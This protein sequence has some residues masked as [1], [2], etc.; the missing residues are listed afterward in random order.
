VMK[1]DMPNPHAIYLHDTPSKQY[2]NSSVRAFSHGCVRTERA[3]E[4]GMT[5]AIF[6]AGLDTDAV[7]ANATSGKYTR[8]P[9]TRTLPIYITYFTMGTSISGSLA[10]FPDIYG[11]DAPVLASFA[12]PRQIKTT[13]R[14]SNE[15]IIKLD[16]PL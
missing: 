8:V 6:G 5:L 7:V 10:S 12:E 9:M 13:Q 3:L 1:I 14:K 11:R 2:F 16:N 15:A 4:L